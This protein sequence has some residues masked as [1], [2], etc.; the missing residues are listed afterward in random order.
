V[1][2]IG[3]RL[4][5]LRLRLLLLLRGL[6]RLGFWNRDKAPL[7][8]RCLT[9]CLGGQLRQFVGIFGKSV[10]ACL[11]FA[12]IRRASSRDRRFVDICR[13]GSS[14]KKRKASG[15]PVASF[16]M[17]D[18]RR[19]SIDQGGGKLRLGIVLQTFNG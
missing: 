8:F 17:K 13:C 4:F 12:E 1:R 16:T 6:L 15:C 9:E 19:S 5:L 2:Q 10:V 7:H 14:S 11:M 18:S 3:R